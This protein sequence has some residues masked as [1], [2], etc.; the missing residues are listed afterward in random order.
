MTHMIF[1]IV[2]EDGGPS[3]YHLHVI[4]FGMELQ[5]RHFYIC[6][7]FF[8]FFSNRTYR[9]VQFIIH[10]LFDVVLLIHLSASLHHQ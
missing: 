8:I 5:N 10:P 4:E 6:L 9:D 7:S 1:S 2:T 3:A